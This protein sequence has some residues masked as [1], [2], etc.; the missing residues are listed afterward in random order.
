MSCY[1]IYFEAFVHPLSFLASFLIC[2]D[3]CHPFMG[4][5]REVVV[6]EFQFTSFLRVDGLIVGLVTF[7]LRTVSATSIPTQIFCV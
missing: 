3:S 4:Y 5:G 7:R 2:V 6:L 1:D